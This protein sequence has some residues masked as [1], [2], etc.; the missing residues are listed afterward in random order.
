MDKM[1]S[2]PI[3]RFRVD[4]SRLCSIGP[5]KVE[6]LESIERTGSLTQAARALGLSYRRAWLLL[7]DINRS[8][9]EPVTIARMGGHLRGGMTLTAVGKQVVRCY[10]AAGRQIEAV[11]Q[12]KLQSIAAKAVRKGPPHPGAPRKRLARHL[13][14]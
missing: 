11:V 3:V 10:R 14:T 8:F 13:H 9:G 6:L 1:A 2:N 4:F 12:S 7:N 5:G